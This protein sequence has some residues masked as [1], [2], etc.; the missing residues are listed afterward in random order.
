M[1]FVRY[2]TWLRRYEH[3]VCEIDIYKSWQFRSG[4]RYPRTLAYCHRLSVIA[5]AIQ[6]RVGR[7][8]QSVRLSPSLMCLL[9][10]FTYPGGGVL[11]VH[12]ISFLCDM[13][14]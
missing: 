2:R 5:T 12:A 9:R 11:R 13:N 4:E 6:G 7:C 3:V 1:A 14:L 10:K 8:I